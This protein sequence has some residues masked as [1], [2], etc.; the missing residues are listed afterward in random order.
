MGDDARWMSQ[1]WLQ[2]MGQGMGIWIQPETPEE[3]VWSF[4]HGKHRPFLGEYFE[5]HTG[6]ADLDQGLQLHP[7]QLRLLFPPPRPSHNV[8]PSQLR[9]A[10]S[11]LLLP[12]G[13]PSAE[14]FPT[15]FSLAPPEGRWEES[16]L[17]ERRMEARRESS[18]G[19]LMLT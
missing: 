3:T 6:L 15:H 13:F 12:Q 10:P 9:Q 14:H 8:P 17:P 16:P 1:Q 19:C 18:S 11:H 2:V 7:L 5:G 4:Y